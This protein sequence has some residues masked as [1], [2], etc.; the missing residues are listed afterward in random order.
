[1]SYRS[2]LKVTTL[3]QVVLFALSLLSVVVVSRLLTPAEIGVFS[4]SVSLLGFAH[5]FREFGVGQYLVQA[6]SVGKP[7]FR[8]AFSVA[9]LFSWGVALL[10]ALL[11]WPLSRL[12]A[13]EGVLQVL[14]LASLNFVAMPFGTPSLAMMRRELQFTRIAW[15]NIAGAVVQT[16]VTIA[17]AWMDQSY[18][19]MAWGSLAMQLSKVLLIQLWRPGEV[20]LL[21]TR[22]GLREVLRFGGLATGASIASSTGQAAPDLILG[23]TLGFAD[24]AYLSRGMSL[25]SM[26]VE[27]VQEVMRTVFFPIFSSQLREGASGSERYL[28]AVGN[29]VA[30]TAPLL[31]LLAIVAD[32]L[33]P[34]MFGDQ[35]TA[36]TR[37]ATIICLAHLASAPFAICGAALTAAG[38]VGT[39]V[40][41]EVTVSVL[42]VLLLGS[43]FWFDLQI[44]VFF[45][46][47]GLVAEA[48]LAYLSLRAVIGLR[49]GTLVRGLWRCYAMAVA[50]G[51]GA[52]FAQNLGDA[53]FAQAAAPRF[54]ELALVCSAGALCWLL[55]MMLFAHPLR[56]EAARLIGWRHG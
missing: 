17:A 51:A 12:Y 54:A 7:Q 3:S 18:L 41:L 24:V 49:L 52:L 55:A 34:W 22:H 27:K 47:A 19:S 53:W 38:A 40:R 10:V 32:P 37:L 15:L 8:A 42:K 11:A 20:W 36:S 16:L 13:H 33:I 44:V 56:H 6:S 1:M 50:T 14:L 26:V 39:L 21:P 25:T 23:K 5:I 46:A 9:L 48:F 2:A 45:I 4:V 28:Q 29:L 30:I 31:V 35:W 43:S